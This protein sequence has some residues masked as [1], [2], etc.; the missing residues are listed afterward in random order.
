M[1]NSFETVLHELQYLEDLSKVD[2]KLLSDENFIDQVLHKFG[3]SEDFSPDQIIDAAAAALRDNSSFILAT[4]LKVVSLGYTRDYLYSNHQESVAYFYDNHVSR[5]LKEEEFCLDLISGYCN[6]SL[7]S[8][9][10]FLRDVQKNNEMEGIDSDNDEN[11]REFLLRKTIS[12]TVFNKPET[13]LKLIDIAG[14]QVLKFL[15]NQFKTIE[16]IYVSALKKNLKAKEFIPADLQ[17]NSEAIKAILTEKN[18]AKAKQE[19]VKKFVALLESNPEQFS[20]VTEGM[21][22]AMDLKNWTELPD[23]VAE[24][25]GK[26]KGN[27]NLNGLSTL[28]DKAAS[29]LMNHKGVLHLGGLVS[30][31][32]TASER[33]FKHKGKINLFSADHRLYYDFHELSVPLIKLIMKYKVS[34]Y[35]SF[36]KLKCITPEIVEAI[37]CF[38]LVIY[39]LNSISDEVAEAFGKFKGGC[40]ELNDLTELSDE[41][42]RQLSAFK[43]QHRLSLASLQKI[44]DQG[45]A[46]LSNYQGYDLTLSSIKSL[47]DEVVSNLAKFKGILTLTG[48]QQISKAHLEVFFAAIQQSRGKERQLSVI[49]C[50]KLWNNGDFD[51]LFTKYAMNKDQYYLYEVGQVYRFR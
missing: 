22:F 37:N 36:R 6:I 47:S 7:L 13:F 10:S 14:W 51:S 38:S 40:L 29:F 46:F 44:T 31:S 35:L 5:F 11:L 33:L 39:G 12:D 20:Q 1:E 15:P 2:A 28:S 45:A 4:F 21:K 50:E 17:E 30:L 3:R 18:S 19:D 25:L 48:I 34:D 26:H 24:A 43:G 42:I 9:P 23:S 32:E 49:L 16:D 41:S 8:D 27:V